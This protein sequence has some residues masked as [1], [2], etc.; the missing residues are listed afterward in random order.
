MKGLFVVGP[1]GAGKTTLTRTLSALH[2]QLFGQQ[3]VVVVN[4]DCANSC[5]CDVDVAEL[6]SL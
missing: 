5:D 1:S 6:A 3:S 2:R 4:L